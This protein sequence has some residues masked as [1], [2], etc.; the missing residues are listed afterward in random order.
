VVFL[1]L[2]APL[3]ST[4]LQAASIRGTVTD[5][6]HAPI[7]GAEVALR[8]QETGFAR[9]TATNAAG[10]YSF[11]DLAVGPYAIEVASAGFRTTLVRGIVLNVADARRVDVP[12]E[13]GDRQ[14]QVAVTASALTV[15]TTGGDLA[16]LID[17]DQVREL[18]L[19]GRNFLQLALLMPGVSPSDSLNLQDKGLLSRPLLSVSGAGTSANL[20]TVDGVNN[21]DVGSNNT[22]LV[23]PSADVIEEFKV[24]RNSYG[25]EYGQANGSQVEIVTRAGT[26]ELHGTAYYFGRD[27][28]LESTDYFL[29]KFGKPK[30]ELAYHDFGLS[31]GGPVV[32]DKLHFFTSLEWNRSTRGTVRTSYVPTAE[33]RAGDFSG[34]AA[35]DCALPLPLDP[36]TGERFPGDR[37]PADRLSPGG[38]LLLRLFP[39]PNTTS[40]DESCLNWVESLDSPTRWREESVRLDWTLSDRT[41]LLLRYTQDSWENQTP[42]DVERTWGDPYPAVDSNFAQSARS[43]VLKLSQT[44]GSTAVNSLQFS[45][46]GNRIEVTRGG[47]DPDLAVRITAAIPTLYP[48]DSKYGGAALRHPSTG[49]APFGG[50]F[51]ASP[52]NNAMDLFALRDDYSQAFGKHMVKAGALYTFNRKDELSLFG[53]APSLAFSTG[54]TGGG[55][56]TGNAVADRLL[57]DMTF[58]F[59]E[60]SQDRRV[61]LRWQD[62][63]LYASD[64]WKIHPRLTLDL[65][66][67]YSHLPNPYAADDTL[68]NFDPSRFEPALGADACNGLLEVPGESGCQA[69][70]FRGGTPGPNRALVR[71]PAGLFAPRLGVTWDVT[72]RGKTSLRLG[73]GEFF[74]REQLNP[75]AALAGN[76]PFVSSRSG[77]R[78]LDTNAEPC[79]GCFTPAQ[80]SPGFGRDVRGLV[81]HNRQ[82]NATLAQQ[83]GTSTTVELS[84]VGSQGVH[85]L[86]NSDINQVRTGDANGNRVSDRLEYVR[87]GGDP[88]G[89][90]RPYGVFGDFPLGY[91]DNGSSSIYHALQTQIRSRFGRGSQLQVSYTWSRLIIANGTLDADPTGVTSDLDNASLDRGLSPLSRRHVLNA[92]LVLRLPELRGQAGLTRH[93]LGNWE[94]GAILAA[95][96][97]APLTIYNGNV[98]GLFGGVS[99]TGDNSNQ[100]PNR[101]PGEPCRATSGPLEQWL[102]P[103]AFTLAGFELGTFGNAG[104]G[105]CEAPSIRQ[106]DLGLYKNIPLGRRLRAQLR[107]EIFNVFNRTQ[108]RN[109]N[110]FLSP[111]SVTLDAPLPAATRITGYELPA[112]F[113]KAGASRDPR[114]AQFGLKLVF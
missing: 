55:G 107:F 101:V 109:V 77:I 17:G 45:Y 65:G 39:L 83:L 41:R 14:E 100:R 70:G 32:K 30:Q 102:N 27:D 76:P 67:R 34:Q 40:S 20:F 21:N 82:W 80:G 4:S 71:N 46:S 104:R 86:R 111:T 94:I 79:A 114:Q 99:G 49:V 96:T 48:L 78:T 66:L 61:P 33:E 24:H 62:L 28:A 22:I 5:P 103:R 95:A 1:A 43:L 47:T 91:S 6:A 113:G 9:S 26:N 15:E 19:N 105:I 63:E 90:L 23:S 13:I 89:D 7:A 3:A 51:E 42:S 64:S 52:W 69:A 81:P 12:L 85:L 75:S 36:L 18:P 108:F 2:D 56:T 84:Y 37:I 8:G 44:L 54:L 10:L 59:F 35:P 110:T 29:A 88:A 73:F 53:E 97:G 58:F 38:T 93:V 92:S 87:L 11:A 57:R 68:T 25:A 50:L 106:V 98:P 31:L 112:T 60:A 74:L 72:G 16:G